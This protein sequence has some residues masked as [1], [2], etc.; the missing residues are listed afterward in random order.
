MDHYNQNYL[1]QPRYSLLWLINRIPLKLYSFW[2]KLKK[3]YINT[4]NVYKWT[5]VKKYY[6]SF[7]IIIN[8]TYGIP[9]LWIEVW[10]QWAAVSTYFSLIKEPTQTR[11]VLFSLV[12][13]SINAIQGYSFIPACSPSRILSVGV[14]PHSP[15]GGSKLA[16]SKLS[17]F[18]DSV[19]D[20]VFFSSSNFQKK[21]LF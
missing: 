1:H 20:M 18:S 17:F 16:E 13:C 7:K 21:I 6:Y 19:S 14:T 15:E 5:W 12:M 3:C 10:T 8:N 4:D 2:K 9:Y 11:V